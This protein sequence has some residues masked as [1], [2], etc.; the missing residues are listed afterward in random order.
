MCYGCW[1]ECEKP[2]IDNEKVRAA[3]PLIAAVYE[4]ACTGGNLHIVL[5]DWNI[6]D[7]NL[8]FCSQCIN[9]AGVMPLKGS[10]VDAHL[11]YNE[12]K[13]ANPD[14]PEQLAAER[15][16]CD[17]FMAMTEDERLS[18]LALYDGYWKIGSG[19]QTSPKNSDERTGDQVR[20][21]R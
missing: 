14:P 1:E 13:R 10:T 5:D 8:E 20:Y 11:R 19:N 4:L 12:D 17:A 6:E 16:C 21:G 2:K 3:V 15:A 7:G 9:G 18:A